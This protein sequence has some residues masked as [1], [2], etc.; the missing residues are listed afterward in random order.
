[1]DRSEYETY[2]HIMRNNSLASIPAMTECNSIYSRMKAGNSNNNKYQSTT[3]Q[4]Y[5]TP[6][7]ATTTTTQQVLSI[8]PT[9]KQMYKM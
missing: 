4:H 5:C 9:N 3:Q 7:P 2:R 6:T 8:S 1:M